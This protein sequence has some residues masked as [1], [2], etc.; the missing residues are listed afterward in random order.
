MKYDSYHIPGA[1][2][3]VELLDFLYIYG[4]LI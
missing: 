2:I 1:W 3:V 4:P